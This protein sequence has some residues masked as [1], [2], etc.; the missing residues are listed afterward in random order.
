MICHDELKEMIAETAERVLVPGMVVGVADHGERVVAATG[1]RNALTGD[2]TTVDTM[3]QIG[4]ITKLYTATMMMQLTDDG[5]V[6]LD[7]PI[8]EHLPE[9]RLAGDP[10]LSGITIEMLLTHTSGIEGD[11]F[12]DTG[13][14][15]D[16][17]EKIIPRLGEIGLIHEPGAGW[18]YCNTGFVLC[19]RII[20]K[21]TGLPWHEALARR[22]VVPLGTIGPLTLLDDVVPHRIALG[23]MPTDG[24]WVAAPLR[25]MPWSQVSAGSRPYGTAED[26]LTFAEMHLSGGV[27][28]DGVQVLRAATVTAMMEHRA[29][30]PRSLT[31]GQGLGWFLLDESPELV[32]AHAGD[33]AGFASLL[34]VV[35]S[36]QLA[37]AALTNTNHGVAANFEVVFRL[38]GEH[39]Q[40]A[41]SP[42]GTVA[43]EPDRV[44]DLQ[45]VTGRY[46]R[47]GVDVDV[48]VLPDGSGLNVVEH[49]VREMEGDVTYVSSLVH[50][51][52][53]VFVDPSGDSPFACEFTDLDDDGRPHGFVSGARL[54]RRI[55]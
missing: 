16:A 41:A 11:C 7:D 33:T 1:V 14:G 19:G 17:I 39:Y 51:G 35:P 13:R 23:H 38:L 25:S 6:R 3:F 18:S 50:H 2:P 15:D 4:S 47:E 34:V 32:V 36:R 28:A 21:I 9:L 45:L 43:A 44:L 24:G 22:L 31:K 49:I 20:E 53:L 40:I 27:A 55:G 46:H 10:D 5:L 8:T 52:Q 37:I 54:L 30:Q 42:P 12:F 48:T 26:L 29:D